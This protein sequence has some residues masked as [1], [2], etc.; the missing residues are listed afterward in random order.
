MN[1]DKVQNLL[2]IFEAPEPEPINLVHLFLQELEKSEAPLDDRGINFLSNCAGVPVRNNRS[3]FL[4]ASEAAPSIIGKEL[5]TLRPILEE[6]TLLSHNSTLKQ[7]REQKIARLKWLAER[8][9]EITEDG[10]TTRGIEMFCH[11]FDHP[12]V[13]NF[14]QLLSFDPA[15]ATLFGVH[16]FLFGVSLLKLGTQKHIDQYLDKADQLEIIGCCMF[17]E[18]GH[19]SSPLFETTATYNRERRGFVIN[20]PSL[21]AQKCWIGGGARNATHGVLF[22][23][24]II[25]GKEYGIH[26]FIVQL[27]GRNG[28]NKP[29][30]TT[31]DLG[32]KM[33]LDGVDN[34]IIHFDHVFVPYDALLDHYCEINHEGQYIGRNGN[35]DSMSILYKLMVNFIFGRKYITMACTTGMAMISTL[36][37]VYPP[38]CLSKKGWEFHLT[39]LLAE[40]FA[41]KYASDLIMGENAYN[42]FNAS[43]MKALSSTANQKSLQLCQNLYDSNPMTRRIRAL[44]NSYFADQA[45][46]LTYE[47]D[48]YLLYM[49]FMKHS[50]DQAKHWFQGMTK[51]RFNS[52]AQL[53]KWALSRKDPKYMILG[54]AFLLAKTIG[55]HLE[56]LKSNEERFKVFNKEFQLMGVKLGKLYGTF[57]ILSEYEKAAK[58]ETEKGHHHIWDLYAI[59]AWN[60]MQ[61]L[62]PERLGKRKGFW[63]KFLSGEK[64]DLMPRYDYIAK[65]HDELVAGFGFKLEGMIDNI[66]EPPPQSVSFDTAESLE[67]R[68]KNAKL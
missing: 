25:D 17:T 48:N 24:L 68:I 57:L 37:Y 11:H 59:Y 7:Q 55:A 62:L 33:G 63:D 4:Q 50:L 27:R 1:V 23:Q 20:T 47:G 66:L 12:I 58:A 34:G 39:N 3:K 32:P 30:V 65:F 46:T 19:G 29:G 56:P 31:T 40:A 26:P 21:T 15:L 54:E 9:P 5:S 42:H 44:V 38:Q 61:E 53:F 10:K 43:I 35:R 28:V 13:R 52:Y 6:T 49:L 8:L 45:A 51:L 22:A 2:T 16:F 64:P 67:S 14:L 36:F 60:Q 18:I 41:F